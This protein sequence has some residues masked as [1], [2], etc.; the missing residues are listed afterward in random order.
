MKKKSQLA[1]KLEKFYLEIEQLRSYLISEGRY[2]MC[3]QT[4]QEFNQNEIKKLNAKHNVEHYNSKLNEGHAVT[5]EQK[6]REPKNRLK[7]FKRLNKIEKKTLKPNDIIKKA[8]ANMNLQPTRKKVDKH[9][10]RYSRYD[11]KSDKKAKKNY[12]H[13]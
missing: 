2:R 10:E 9:A 5:A 8:T 1:E 12:V 3:L 11:R 6:I 4:D 13:R 7:N